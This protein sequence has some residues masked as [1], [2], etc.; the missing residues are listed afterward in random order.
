M[1]IWVDNTSLQG[2]ANKGS[3]KSHALTW[4]LQ[5]ARNELSPLFARVK[6]H[7]SSKWTTTLQHS[8]CNRP[9]PALKGAEADNQVG[10]AHTHHV[11]LLWDGKVMAN[12]PDRFAAQ[13]WDPSLASRRDAQCAAWL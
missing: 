1:D 4:G 11:V 3:S 9:Q 8:R 12:P 5:R 10:V 6:V 2:A 13:G 7:G